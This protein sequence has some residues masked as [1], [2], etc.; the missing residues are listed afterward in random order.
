MSAAH[1]NLVRER[2]RFAWTISGPPKRAVHDDRH[3]SENEPRSS[4]TAAARVRHTPAMLVSDH[5]S[6]ID[7]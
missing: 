5:S 1:I 7:G 4:A 3:S 2:D 6:P